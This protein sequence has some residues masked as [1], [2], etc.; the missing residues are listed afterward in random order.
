VQALDSSGE[1][2]LGDDEVE[3]IQNS[4]FLGIPRE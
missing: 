4:T 2:I 3:M 1:I